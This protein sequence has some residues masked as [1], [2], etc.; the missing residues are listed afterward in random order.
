M[1]DHED[2]MG[3]AALRQAL[4]DI[5]RDPG[6]VEKL[7]D[8]LGEAGHVFTWHASEGIWSVP[9]GYKDYFSGCLAEII[10]ERPNLTHRLLKTGNRLIKMLTYRALE[11]Q[12][13]A[14]AKG[15]TVRELCRLDAGVT[16]N[17]RWRSRRHD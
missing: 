17:S 14:D 11:I 3:E 4:A 6:L 16:A 10:I 1:K 7:Q 15:V 5:D 9:E 12:K 13:E 8:L 2:I